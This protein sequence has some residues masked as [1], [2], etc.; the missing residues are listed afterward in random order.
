MFYVD[1]LKWSLRHFRNQLFESILVVSA[2]ALGVGILI[3]V[4]TLFISVNKVIGVQQFDE[5]MRTL[6]IITGNMSSSIDS[7]LIMIGHEEDVVEW[8]TTLIELG[9]FSKRLPN[10]MHAFVETDWQVT[11]PLLDGK[12]DNLPYQH[13]TPLNISLLGTSPE[14]FDF[15]KYELLSGNLFLHDDLHNNNRVMVIND[16]LA[17]YLFGHSDVVDKLIPVN[18][19]SEES[20]VIYYKVIGVFKCTEKRIDSFADSQD[21]LAV[22][23]AS[24]P[25]YLFQNW[26]NLAGVPQIYRWVFVGVDNGENMALAKETI[27]SEAALM[28]GKG[29]EVTGTFMYYTEFKKQLLTYALIIGILA[30]VSLAIA[31]INILNLMLNRVLKRTKSIGLSIA[32]GGTR[33]QIFRQFLLEALTLGFFGS[34]LGIWFSSVIIKIMKLTI[35]TDFFIGKSTFEQILLGFGIGILISLFFGTYPAYLGFRTNPVDALR[36]D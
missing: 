4:L 26:D 9:E 28:W 1:Q 2:I 7:P 18:S 32:L 16:L 24:V 29:F 23:P 3:S 13:D 35:G 34:G 5:Q 15:K 19:L 31:I 6:E 33:Q 17:D 10:T 20:E 27:E 22:V 12:D 25:P 36:T 11:I 21:L 8:G 30:S 14:Y